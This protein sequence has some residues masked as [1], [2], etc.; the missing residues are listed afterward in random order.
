MDEHL[1]KFICTSCPEAPANSPSVHKLCLPGSQGCSDE[2]LGSGNVGKR[3]A[4]AVCDARAGLGVCRGLRP[5]QKPEF[6]PLQAYSPPLP[7]R[8]LQ[9]WGP[10]PASLSP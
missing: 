3:T 7:D 6:P 8:H 10:F 4:V 9:A 1:H 5:A 2:V